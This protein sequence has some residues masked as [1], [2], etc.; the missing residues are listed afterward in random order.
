MYC[1]RITKFPKND[2]SYLFQYLPLLTF[3]VIHSTS[4]MIIAKHKKSI[5]CQ[6]SNCH[7][8]FFSINDQEHDLGFPAE[9]GASSVLD[10][11][12]QMVGRIT[13]Q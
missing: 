11:V 10:Q 3:R 6:R 12:S 4:L 9:T 2:Q 7:A 5:F 1:D 8:F 13:Q